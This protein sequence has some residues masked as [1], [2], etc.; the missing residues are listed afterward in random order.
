VV[1]NA[2]A[3]IVSA[4][5]EDCRLVDDAMSRRL[6]EEHAKKYGFIESVILEAC[7]NAI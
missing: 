6:M 1:I 2:N 7:E 5:V 4:H 3:Y